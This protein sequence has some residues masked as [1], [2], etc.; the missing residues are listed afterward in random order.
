[1]FFSSEL[2]AA[3][4]F[5]PEPIHRGESTSTQETPLPLPGMPAVIR[6]IEESATRLWQGG[7]L[8]GA[9]RAVV[10]TQLGNE[11]A[12]SLYT[13]AGFRIQPAGLAVLRRELD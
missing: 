7:V 2:R 3:L 13:R 5:C 6:I 11:A 9:A 12:L 8:R 10:N 4:L 1:M